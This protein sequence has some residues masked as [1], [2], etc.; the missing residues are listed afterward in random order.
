LA[1][2]E[3]DDVVARMNQATAIETGLLA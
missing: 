3:D 1:S 2:I